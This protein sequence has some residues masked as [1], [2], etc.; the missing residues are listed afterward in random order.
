[1]NIPNGDMVGHINDVEA[2]VVSC[3][4]ADEAVKVKLYGIQSLSYLGLDLID[5]YR[6]GNFNPLSDE[7]V[8]FG[9]TLSL[10]AHVESRSTCFY[11]RPAKLICI[12]KK[13][14]TKL[15]D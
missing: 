9:H 14:N 12:S 3:K 4:A 1:M 5:I 13:F 15:K 6:S 10:M 8:G 7:C 11:I 2:I